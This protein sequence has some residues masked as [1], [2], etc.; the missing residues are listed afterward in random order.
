MAK[1]S[2][3]ETGSVDERWIGKYTKF[4]D[5]EKHYKG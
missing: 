4:A 2:N 1:A 5:P 3:G